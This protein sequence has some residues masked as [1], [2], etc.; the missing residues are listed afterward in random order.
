MW[1]CEIIRLKM[2]PFIL[3]G[4]LIALF[5]FISPVAVPMVDLVLPG[6]GRVIVVAR[7]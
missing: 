5:M 6:P 1:T 3:D 2:V 4:Y 7:V